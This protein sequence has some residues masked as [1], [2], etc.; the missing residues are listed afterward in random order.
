MS[1]YFIGDIVSLRTHPFSELSNNIIISGEYLMTPPTMIISEIISRTPEDEVQREDR[2]KCI[3]FSSRKNDFLDQWFS[4]SDLQPVKVPDSDPVIPIVIG[5]LVSLKNLR[6]EMGKR[7][8]YLQIDSK[9]S[10]G[11]TQTSSISAHMTYISPVM[12]VIEIKNH[13]STKLP[14]G[15][16]KKDKIFPSQIVKCKY[17][18]AAQEKYSEE[19]L[20]I[21]VLSALPTVP[22]RLIESLEQIITQSSYLLTESMI[23]KPV[24]I[25]CKSGIYFM[26]A[27]DP[28][29]LQNRDIELAKLE[30]F[31]AIKSPFLNTSPRYSVEVEGGVTLLK[32]KLNVVQFVRAAA[33]EP[34]KKFL[35]IKYS[36]KY[37]NHTQRTIDNY[38][39][40]LGLGEDG[41]PAQ[42]EYLRAYCNLRKAIRHF[43]LNG[44]ME[45][46]RMALN[47]P[48]RT[49]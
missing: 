24:N 21:E 38:D 45:A 41:T 46:N 25:Y 4:D 15:I 3:W 36:D 2:Y 19:F 7:R 29:Q 1:K 44:I 42:T 30:E 23:L 11:K 9:L 43:R 39:I 27:Y 49:S 17:Y 22:D 31:K 6:I 20:P 47:Y 12:L 16:S 37:G 48:V 13:D 10:G 8:S 40:V 26:G 33:I 32:Q 14:K 34:E 5:S 18:N 35:Y 28:I